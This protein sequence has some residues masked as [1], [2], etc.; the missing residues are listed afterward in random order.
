MASVTI[1]MA[2]APNA[3]GAVLATSATDG[4]LDR[5]EAER[6]QHDRGDRDR[7]A[8]AGQRLQQRAEAERD[9]D[10]LDPLVVTDPGERPAQHVE[11]P[12]HHGHVVDP[13]RVDHDPQDRE[14]AERRALGR[15][16]ERL[17]DRHRVDEHGDEERDEQRDQRGHPGPHPQH[18]EQDEQRQQGQHREQRAQRE[19]VGY[20][21]QDLARYMTFTFHR[22]WVLLGR[23]R[24][25]SGAG[26]ASM[27][28][29][30]RRGGDRPRI[31]ASSTST[32][33]ASAMRPPLRARS[34]T[35]TCIR[36]PGLAVTSS[37][38]PVRHDV[39]G[40]AVARARAPAPGLSRL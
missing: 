29:S 1:G 24:V 38:A 15:R 18:A 22:Q 33:W 40:L 36:Q 17:P 20:R 27:Q 34:R 32:V 25:G 6:D 8:E 13:D 9:D 21:V 14:E 2:R 30:G 26:A 37:S 31:E 5:P 11:V 19:R 7:G 35:A 3:T 10:R 16:P 4:G 12:G 23:I 28:W 39:G